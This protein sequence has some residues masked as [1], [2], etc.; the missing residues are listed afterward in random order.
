MEGKNE[1]KTVG[2]FATF[3]LTLWFIGWL[4][5]IGIAAVKNALDSYNKTD[6]LLV[7]DSNHTEGKTQAV[8]VT[9]ES[10]INE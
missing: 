5:V 4:I 2:E 6:T 7:L 9:E 1:Y 3:H 8:K 10:V